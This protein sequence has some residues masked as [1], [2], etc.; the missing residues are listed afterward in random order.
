M[1]TRDLFAL[2]LC[3]V[4]AAALVSVYVGLRNCLGA[5]FILKGWK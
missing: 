3:G 2:P 4:Y 1:R 5:N